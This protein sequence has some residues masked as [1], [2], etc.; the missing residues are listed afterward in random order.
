M[1]A[2][3]MR[4]K[5]EMLSNNHNTDYF[6]YDYESLCDSTVMSMWWDT[7][8][9]ENYFDYYGDDATSWGGYSSSGVFDVD[10]V[11]MAMEMGTCGGGPQ[12]PRTFGDY[13]VVVDDDEVDTGG[14]MEALAEVTKMLFEYDGEEQANPVESMFGLTSAL[15]GNDD[16]KKSW[17]GEGEW[18]IEDED[19]FCENSGGCFGGMSCDDVVGVFGPEETTCSALES[20]GCD[21][22]G[23]SCHGGAESL[24]GAHC[25]L[26]SECG[27]EGLVCKDW[28]EGQGYV[29]HVSAMDR[30]LEQM[31]MSKLCVPQ[32]WELPVADCGVDND[33]AWDGAFTCASM[34]EHFGSVVCENP[35]VLW[36]DLYNG[37][38]EEMNTNMDKFK[39][40]CN[41]SCCQMTAAPTQAPT[42]SPTDAP[43]PTATD[44]PTDAP[45]AAPTDAPTTA[46]TD[47]SSAPL[48]EEVEV[49]VTVVSVT[50]EE[51]ITL[52]YVEVPEEPE[53]LQ[54]FAN[55]LE[56]SLLQVIGGGDAMKVAITKINGVDVEL[57]RRRLDS[58]G[59]EA[60]DI[61]FSITTVQVCEDGC[62]DGDAEG[63]A[64]AELSAGLESLEQNIATL[65]EVMEAEAARVVQD[66]Q[67]AGLE[68]PETLADSVASIA[69]MEEVSAGAFEAPDDD[70]L[71]SSVVTDVEDTVVIELVEV[72]DGAD[73]EEEEDGADVEE[74]ED[75]ADV[76]EEEDGADVEDTN[77]MLGDSGDAAR[78]S[79]GTVGGLTVAIIAFALM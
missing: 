39:T 15:L 7:Y 78:R 43:T 9:Q 24:F 1:Y 53:A 19:S 45:S 59:E 22:S 35:L 40:E 73:V 14:A 30:K 37:F 54:L 11:D 51:A 66:M 17:W 60:L 61:E 4:M 46:S 71:R 58:V 77:V 63:A 48:M 25:D 34:V 29:N 52:P 56:A 23:C 28:P 47:A 33:A 67:D 72:E 3:E 36:Y 8:E 44:A 6:D 10:D 38:P 31:S 12:V 62:E 21:C 26:D 16:K 32:D 5:V 76:E 79:V 64:L 70:E 55:I 41:L 13:E 74:E 50:Y 20:M 2:P 65:D 18:A 75:G 27:G 49:I 68:V 42:T 57:S 69:E